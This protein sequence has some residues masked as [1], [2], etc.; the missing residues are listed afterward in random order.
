MA[1]QVKL[2]DAGIIDYY[3]GP[4]FFLISLVLAAFSGFNAA[5]LVLVGM[6]AIWSARLCVHLVARH[7]GSKS[8]DARYAA[9][10]AAGGPT[11]WWKSLF[12]IFLLQGALQWMIA[13]PLHA[14]FLLP[15]SGTATDPLFLAG[16]LLFSIGFAIESVADRQL[17]YFRREAKSGGN[18]M[19]SV[20]G[21]SQASELSRGNDPLDWHWHQRVWHHRFPV[22]IRGTGRAGA[23]MYFVSIPITEDHLRASRPEFASYASRTPVLLPRLFALVNYARA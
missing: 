1:I 23:V 17:A 3:W 21:A 11:F 14:A 13:S 20:F 6:V 19:T 8:E 4:G 22:G 12:T 9:M 2:N 10:R 15:S 7:R 5:T 18:L 16:A